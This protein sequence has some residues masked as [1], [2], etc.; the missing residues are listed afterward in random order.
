[1]TKEEGNYFVLKRLLVMNAP[2]ASMGKEADDIAKLP[3]TEDLVELDWECY[4]NIA[5]RG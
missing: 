5:N 3:A 1:M 4:C 2:S